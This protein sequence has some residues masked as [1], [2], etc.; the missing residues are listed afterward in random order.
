[1]PVRLVRGIPGGARIE[2]LLANVGSRLGRFERAGDSLRVGAVAT[3]AGVFERL[4]RRPYRPGEDPIHDLVHNADTFAAAVDGIPEWISLDVAAVADRGAAALKGVGAMTIGPTFAGSPLVGGADA[5]FISD[6][7]LWDVKSS[8]KVELRIRDVHQL[9][10]YTLL[11][12]DDRFE[13]TQ[14]GIC[15]SR[16]GVT[17][18]WDVEWLLGRSIAEARTEVRE[19][20]TA[21]AG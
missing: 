9:L 4:T 7:I 6:G 17:D 11:D 12:F 8:K 14:V 15:S 20:L 16:F 21:T 3:I 13:I 5:D 19:V 10:G 18:C 1:M 2:V